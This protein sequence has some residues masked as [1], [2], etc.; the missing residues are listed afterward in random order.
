MQMPGASVEQMARSAKVRPHSV[1]Y[2]M[3]QF[4]DK[5]LLVPFYLVRFSLF[6]LKRFN[7]F[8]SVA[9][10]KAAAVI[11][12]L[13]SDPRVIWLTEQAGS[14]RYELVAIAGDVLELDVLLKKVVMQTGAHF[15][16][17]LWAIETD[18]Y[19]FGSRYLGSA[20]KKVLWQDSAPAKS[21]SVKLAKLDID[22]IS[23]LCGPVGLRN[24]S[25]SEL[26]RHLRQPQTT[27]SYH[28][29]KLTES[30]ILS[31]KM[32][33]L[34]MSRAGLFQYQLVLTLNSTNP[35]LHEQ[36]LK[37]CQE[38]PAIIALMRGFGGWDYKILCQGESG[39]NGLDVRDDLE[40]LFPNAFAGITVLTR[41]NIF[42]SEVNL[43]SHP[44][45]AWAA[46]DR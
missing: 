27:V 11:R 14:P 34:S 7:F 17:R 25:S 45:F 40:R 42:A 24:A 16:D 22:I 9:P 26:A 28:L 8:F 36:L 46:G 13:K 33:F 18:F 3:Q 4:L 10:S 19:H 12:L 21:E 43:S 35:S 39:M 30:G 44:E 6:N 15:Q 2:V 32:Y 37:F 20:G 1:R 23:C 29:K 31:Q 5:E 41:R 38:R